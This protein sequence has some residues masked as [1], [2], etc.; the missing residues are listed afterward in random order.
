MRDSQKGF[1]LVELIVVIAIIIILVA[2]A[3][4][5]L[6]SLIGNA[7]LTVD[8]TN[9]QTL[10]A[11]ARYQHILDGEPLLSGADSYDAKN[12]TAAY[13]LS[14]YSDKDFLEKLDYF[15][16]NMMPETGSNQYGF[17]LR[18]NGVTDKYYVRWGGTDRFNGVHGA[19]EGSVDLWYAK[20]A[21]T[22]LTPL[23]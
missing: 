15:N 4:P 23:D 3:V 11:A 5:K 21:K 16:T 9:A 2:I 1:T 22:S 17:W 12:L 13:T 7:E 6:T 8:L 19:V 18:Y 10:I 20:D 14:L